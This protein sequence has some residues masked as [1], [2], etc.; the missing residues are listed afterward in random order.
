MIV[1][2]CFP[3]GY[4]AVDQVE[5]DIKEMVELGMKTA[6][7]RK[8]G[9]TVVDGEVTS[10][11]SRYTHTVGNIYRL[12]NIVIIIVIIIILRFMFLSG[13]QITIHNQQKAVSIVYI[14]T[15]TYRMYL[16]SSA[17]V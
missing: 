1:R 9:S 13:P 8:T 11:G 5:L 16:T 15:H 2:V 4:I 14:L 3:D 7:N 12:N 10:T 17:A 6:N